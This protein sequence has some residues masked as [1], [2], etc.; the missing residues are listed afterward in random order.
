M[1]AK[2]IICG[3]SV[4]VLAVAL[5]LAGCKPPQS[6]T[7][8]SPTPTFGEPVSTP[9]LYSF[10]DATGHPLYFRSE[11]EMKYAMQHRLVRPVVTPTPAPTGYPPPSSPT[12]SPGKG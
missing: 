6:L 5:M 10:D 3:L 11:A 12:S 2:R 1:T 8:P 7:P 9:T 4:L